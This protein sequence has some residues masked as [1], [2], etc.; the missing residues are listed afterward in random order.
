M[1][2]FPLTLSFP[3]KW[4]S[5]YRIS[6]FDLKG[7]NETSELPLWLCLEDS[8]FKEI[9]YLGLDLQQKTEQLVE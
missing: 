8:S 4:E 3:W 7:Q 9:L 6:V 1:S 2:G 5:K